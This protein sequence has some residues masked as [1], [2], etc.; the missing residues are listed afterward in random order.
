MWLRKPYGAPVLSFGLVDTTG[1]EPRKVGVG[2]TFDI[3]ELDQLQGLIMN[4][5]VRAGSFA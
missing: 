5:K 2:L 1:H 4:A 3:S